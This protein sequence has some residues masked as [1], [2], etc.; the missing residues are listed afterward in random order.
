LSAVNGAI[1]AA[2]LA[3]WTPSGSDTPANRK[4]NYVAGS[5]SILVVDTE[6]TDLGPY[7]DNLVMANQMTTQ[8]RASLEPY[9]QSRPLRSGELVL[10]SAGA[11]LGRNVVCSGNEVPNTPRGLAVPLGYNPCTASN[12]SGD[13]DKYFLN[14]AE[15]AAIVTA[16]ATYN[17]VIAGVVSALNS[18][19]ADIALVDVQPTFVDMLGL[20][21]ATAGALAL[22]TGRADG[23]K[24][25]NV[26]GFQLQP[27][28]SPNGVFSTDAVHPNARGHAI[29]ANLIIDA[30]NDRWGASI[31]KV[32]VLSQ[33]GV[34]L[35]EN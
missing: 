25:L 4:T 31:P 24:G 11:V 33:L 17:G 10:L 34:P 16:R 6:L 14:S 35:T 5:N 13:G 23:V 8:Q 7:W 1:D 18:G 22:P 9:R 21:A 28:F 12:E 3:G 20:D 15:Q 2:T 27:D 32:D 30:I 26:G 29:I 19:G